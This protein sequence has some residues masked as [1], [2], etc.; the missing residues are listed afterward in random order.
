MAEVVQG[1]HLVM[2]VEVLELVL[3]DKD[4]LAVRVQALAT[5]VVVVLVVLELQV[6]T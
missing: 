3:L 6:M 5:V 4:M 2:L 1:P